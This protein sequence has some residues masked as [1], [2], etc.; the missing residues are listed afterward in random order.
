MDHTNVD[1]EIQKGVLIILIIMMMAIIDQ[2]KK[3]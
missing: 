1:K 2:L 3:F